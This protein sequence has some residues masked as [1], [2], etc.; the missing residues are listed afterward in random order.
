MCRLGRAG[1]RHLLKNA[2]YGAGI[3]LELMC[4]M[5][6][7]VPYLGVYRDAA[8]TQDTIVDVLNLPVAGDDEVPVAW[9]CTT[10]VGAVGKLMIE[11]DFRRRG[12]G[13]LLGAALTRQQA[14]LLGFIP[15]VFIDV[16]NSASRAMMTKVADSCYSHDAFWLRN[17]THEETQR[18]KKQQEA[19]WPLRGRL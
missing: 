19:N 8:V 5:A 13:S 12:L 14:A 10:P 2:E 1:I 17:I 18:K 7:Q 4:A 11:K 15:H 3:P 16:T 6:Q 9:I